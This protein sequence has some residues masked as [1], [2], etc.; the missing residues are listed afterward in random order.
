M[1]Q[2]S[3]K[4]DVNMGRHLGIDFCRLLVDFG[5]QVGQE[6]RAKR[7]PNAVKWNPVKPS[8]SSQVKPS[9][10]K[11]KDVAGPFFSHSSWG[12]GFTS[13]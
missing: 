9:Q 13:S 2:K 1:V 6:N 12:E 5:G 10:A 11:S 8:Q 7:E 3:I 4:N